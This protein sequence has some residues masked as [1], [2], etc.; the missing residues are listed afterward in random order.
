MVD[1][2]V[3]LRVEER[4]RVE[5]KEAG[6]QKRRELGDRGVVGAHGG[7]VAKAR[8]ADFVFREDEFVHQSLKPFAC[9]QHG[10]RFKDCETSASSPR[11][12]RIYERLAFVGGV[13]GSES[14]QTRDYALATLLSDRR[15]V[16]R[17]VRVLAQRHQ[18]VVGCYQIPDQKSPSD[19]AD[20]SDRRNNR[21][22]SEEHEHAGGSVASQEPR[23]ARVCGGNPTNDV[24]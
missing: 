7:V 17:K 13:A 3:G 12:N 9:T 8:V 16:E 19:E 21:Q 14:L 10:M 18:P 11:K 6:Q 15:V 23:S 4:A 1:G 22:Y 24:D 2:G 20:D 5:T